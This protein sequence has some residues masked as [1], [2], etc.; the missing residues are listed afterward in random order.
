MKKLLAFLIVFI[1]VFS[2][3]IHASATVHTTRMI[4]IHG[5]EGRAVTLSRD[6]DR[7]TTP[8]EAQLLSEGHTLTTGSASHVHLQKDRDS[9]LH[10]D[11]LS[12]VAVGSSGNNLSLTIQSGSVFS[13]VAEQS[14]GQTISSRIGNV[15]LGIQ[16]AM[17]TMSRDVYG[18]VTIVMLSGS[19]YINDVLLSAGSVMVVYDGL[20]ERF[21]THD[22]V[23]VSGHYYVIFGIEIENLDLHTLTAIY[24]NSEY[25][26]E[27]GTVTPEDVALIP[28]LIAGLRAERDAEL[29]ERSTLARQIQR[30]RG[31]TVRNFDFSR[32]GES[33]TSTGNTRP[34]T[35]SGAQSTPSPE[36]PTEKPSEPPS[37]SWVDRP[38]VTPPETPGEP[39]TESPVEPPS[40]TPP[41]TP[42]DSPPVEPPSGEP[43]VASPPVKPPPVEPPP[44][45]PPAEPPPGEPPPA[46]CC[47][48]ISTDGLTGSTQGVV[49]VARAPWRLCACGVL[50]VDEGSITNTSIFQG[51]WHTHR[52]AINN[53]VFTGP[54]TAGEYLSAL[55][56][57]LT[58]VTTIE[59]LHYFDTSNVRSMRNM[60]SNASSL[61]SLDLSGFDTSRVTSMSN[62]FGNASSLTSLDLSGFDTERVT[63]M[64]AM[65]SGASGLTSLDLSGFNTG[66]VTDMGSMFHGASG[67]T[68]LDLSGWDTGSLTSVNSMFH[69]ASGL[70]SLDLSGWNISNVTSMQLLFSGTSGLISLNLSGW[71]NRNVPT[72]GM[73]EVFAGTNS[74]SSLTLGAHFRF[75]GNHWLQTGNWQLE[76]SAGSNQELPTTGAAGTWVWQ[77]PAG[78]VHF[79]YSWEELWALLEELDE[80]DRQAAE[81]EQADPD[82]SYY[83][84]D[85]EYDYADEYYDYPEDYEYYECEYE[86]EDTDCSE[87]ERDYEYKDADDCS[88]YGYNY[89][90]ENDVTDPCDSYRKEDEYDKDPEDDE[91]DGEDEGDDSD[92]TTDS[93]DSLYRKEDEY[94]KDPEEDEDEA[95]S[96]DS[97]DDTDTADDSDNADDVDGAED[98]AVDVPDVGGT[99]E[100]DDEPEEPSVHDELLK[101]Y[102]NAADESTSVEDAS[103]E[104]EVD[105][106]PES[107]SVYDELLKMYENAADEKGSGENNNETNDE[108]DN[109]PEESSVYDE[110]L[111]MYGLD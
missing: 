79:V 109:E 39:P 22:G 24:D 1:L 94:A 55:F 25:L 35:Y 91:D 110:L 57:G 100:V 16:G 10:M 20:V 83:A 69:R 88:E 96:P 12:S 93:D 72:N 82:D 46:Q 64:V 18:F 17:Y 36:T 86:Y 58:N 40:V 76:S 84:E 31:N 78:R 80:L 67:L 74:L 66:R 48:V 37:D 59:G 56:S 28:D 89:D 27:V 42:P 51:P 3:I 38:S 34:P 15:G 77:S 45:N 29:G 44:A 108:A 99:D 97:D 107:P 111:K 90:D 11:E 19:G 7:G 92:E 71:D 98:V 104:I 81:K 53:I 26:I 14:A 95:D 41:G 87:Y 6:N 47:G 21:V 8:R 60:F 5:M 62:M 73:L 101:M 85:Y 54:I 4:S 49:G 43:P 102:E 61:T 68:S 30:S 33:A 70:T 65:F 52:A 50:T 2:P 105:D 32:E 9:T 75:F 63:D 23:L 106:E 103:P 13:N